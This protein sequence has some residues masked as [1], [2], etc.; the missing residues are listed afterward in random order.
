MIL[1]VK[2]GNREIDRVT[3][4]GESV[5][6]ATR[7]ASSIVETKIDDLGMDRAMHELRSWSNGY[8]TFSEIVD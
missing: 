1:I 3:V 7:A 4:D 5:T 8:I 2:S 6:Y